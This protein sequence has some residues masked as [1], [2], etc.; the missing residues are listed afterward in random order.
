MICAENSDTYSVFSSETISGNIHKN[1][2]IRFEID[3]DTMDLK[4]ILSGSIKIIIWCI[5]LIIAVAIM[6]P[7]YIYAPILRADS[8][9]YRCGFLDNGYRVDAKSCRYLEWYI[10]NESSR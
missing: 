9:S 6:S 3:M 7:S 2:T 4:A 5:S 10:K 1:N 8:Y